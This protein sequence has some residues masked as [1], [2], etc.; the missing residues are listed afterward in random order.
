MVLSAFLPHVGVHALGGLLAL[1]AVLVVTGYNQL[2]AAGDPSRRGVA[3]VFTLLAGIV[4]VLGA[5]EARKRLDSTW[6]WTWPHL[7]G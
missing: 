6:Y 7:S 3:W 2:E 5:L 1:R 4:V